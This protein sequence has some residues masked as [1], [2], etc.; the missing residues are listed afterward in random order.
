M[1]D[2][3]NRRRFPRADYPCRIKIRDKK[4]KTILVARTDNVGCGGIC[5]VLEKNLGL[6]SNV[7]LELDL[8]DGSSPIGA[9]GMVVW[10]VKRHEIKK[11]E[12]GNFDTGIEFKNLDAA[13]VTRIEAIVEKCL[14][15]DKAQD[16]S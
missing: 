13:G 12:A 3:I 7:D 1:W 9:E 15:K 16:K 8:E 5:A 11:E 2:G 10:V 4:G 14:E 6:F